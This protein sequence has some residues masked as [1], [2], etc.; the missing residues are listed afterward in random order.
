MT[1]RLFE[2]MILCA[3]VSEND[4]VSVIVASHLIFLCKVCECQRT[5]VESFCEC[6]E[7]EYVAK[8]FSFIARMMCE[9]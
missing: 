1:A 3:C 6:F 4:L 9:I 2:R 5:V 8:R 7:A